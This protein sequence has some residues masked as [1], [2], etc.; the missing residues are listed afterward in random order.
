MI[1]CFDLQHKCDYQHYGTMIISDG[2]IYKYNLTT[3]HC[4][5]NI[6]IRLKLHYA[7]YTGKIAPD[8]MQQ[9]CFLLCGLSSQH[10]TQIGSSTLTGYCLLS[11]GKWKKTMLDASDNPNERRLIQQLL[12][13]TGMM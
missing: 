6:P 2:S 1:C 8:I 11:N 10:N 5:T 9:L 13:L 7:Q 3:T 4:A 12:D